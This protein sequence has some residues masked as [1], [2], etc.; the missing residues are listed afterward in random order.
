MA[1]S[2]QTNADAFVGCL[3]GTAVGDALGLPYEGLSRRR[4]M[5]L[6]GTPD[7]MR[8]VFRY[9]MISDDTEHACMVAQSLLETGNELTPFGPPLAWRLRWWFA[10]LPAGTGLA[11]ARACLR[12]WLGA[13]HEK[14]GVHSAGNGPAM[15]AGI[16]GVALEDERELR[17]FVRVS[18]RLTHTDIKAEYGALAIAIAAQLAAKQRTV[19]GDQ[20][21]QTL[22]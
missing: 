16:L 18:T 6:W 14:S 17:E 9:G 20:Y 1:L 15:R 8:F 4:A 13:S 7:R 10:G 21:L 3:L 11:T 22:E 19:G 12:L 5:R 2:P